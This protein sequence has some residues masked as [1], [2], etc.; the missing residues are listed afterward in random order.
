MKIIINLA[1]YC[2][3]DDRMILEKEQIQRYLRHIIMPEISGPG[4]KKL[5][6]SSI[7]VYCD[8]ISGSAVLLY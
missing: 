1:K 8:S 3:G 5:L 6:E 2:S 4:Q 7:L